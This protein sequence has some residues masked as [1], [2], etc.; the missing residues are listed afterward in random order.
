MTSRQIEIIKFAIAYLRSSIGED[1]HFSA[2][3]GRTPNRVEQALIDE[4]GEIEYPI[5]DDD[6]ERAQLEDLPLSLEQEIERVEELFKDQASI[7]A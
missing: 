4:I 3:I 2:G 5:M 1:T 6:I 7:L